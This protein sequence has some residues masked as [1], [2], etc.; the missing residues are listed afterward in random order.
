MS[1]TQRLYTFYVLL[2]WNKAMLGLINKNV[3]SVYNLFALKL[4]LFVLLVLFI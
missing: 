4:L 1:K 3:L 2:M